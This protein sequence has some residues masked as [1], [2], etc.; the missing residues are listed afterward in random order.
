MLL[1]Q[2]LTFIGR[3]QFHLRK[4]RIVVRADVNSPRLL[5]FGLGFWRERIISHIEIVG[6]FGPNSESGSTYMV[7][8]AFI[9]DRGLANLGF[10]ANPR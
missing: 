10:K 3:D 8:V 6:S 2:S 4:P 7:A 1:N 5:R 9:Q